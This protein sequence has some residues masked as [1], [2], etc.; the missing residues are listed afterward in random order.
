[1]S[2][3]LD[4]LQPEQYERAFCFKSIGYLLG[5]YCLSHYRQRNML[6]VFDH[7]MFRMYIQKAAMAKTLV[8]GLELFSDERKFTEFAQGFREIIVE[9]EAYIAKAKEMHSV[10]IG[11]LQDLQNLLDKLYYYFEKT[12]FF[13]TDA[14]YEQKTPTL[15][16]N[17]FVLGDDLK[18]K[19]RPLLIELLTTVLYRFASLAIEKQ[20]LDLEEVK[21]W[22]PEELTRF[23]KTG[24]TVP[25]TISQE[26]RRGFVLASYNEKEVE[27]LEGADKETI[28]KRFAEPKNFSEVQTFTGKVANIGKVTARARVILA[29]LNEDYETFAKKV[30]LMEMHEGEIL[31][32]ETTSPEFVPLMKK[33][34]GIIANQGGL[35]SHA[36]IM[37]RELNVPCLVGTKHATD[38][39][40]TGDLIM[41]DA[42]ST[43]GQVT[44]IERAA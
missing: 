27:S 2:D 14:C 18:M 19:S 28:L 31:V 7:D 10:T 33:A 35:N 29:N 41:L 4:T 39:L 5:Y 26:R 23:L 43:P 37:S 16:K 21:F 42:I 1:M 24:E 17:L 32:T 6:V 9:C 44:I 13:F 15:E 34:G 40:R 20:R 36:A 8:Q 30:H 12:E 38:I 3:F 11:D 22:S 25:M